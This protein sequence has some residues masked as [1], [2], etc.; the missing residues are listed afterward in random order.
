VPNQN[1]EIIAKEFAK[2]FKSISP[3]SVNTEVRRLHYGFPAV[4]PLNSKGINAAA[5]ALLKAFGKKAVFTREGGSIPIVV[6][7]MKQLNAPAVL[8]GLGLDSDNIHSPNEHFRLENFEKGLYSAA[9]F[10]D[11]LSKL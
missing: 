5:S 8:M 2:F 1:P 7:F 10:L 11:E 3:K 6:D 9:Y 4:A